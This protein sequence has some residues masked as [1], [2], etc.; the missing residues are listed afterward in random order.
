M[1]MDLEDTVLDPAVEVP[2]IVGEIAVLMNVN[3]VPD[4]ISF[5]L[6]TYGKENHDYLSEAPSARVG[7]DLHTESHK[8]RRISRNTVSNDPRI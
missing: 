4:S 7:C 2:D 8:V 1:M 6:D 5:G 3:I